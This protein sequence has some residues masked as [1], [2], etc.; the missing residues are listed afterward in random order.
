MSW[1]SRTREPTDVE[2][3]SPLRHRSLA[4][5]PLLAGLDPETRHSALDLGA[6]VGHNL[7]LLSARGCRIRITDL[8][9]SLSVETLE[10]REPEA[11]GPLFARLLPF[12]PSERFDVVFLWDLL[13]YLRPHEIAALMARVTSACAPRAVAL[14]LVSTLRQ[15]PG[16]PRR[17]RIEDEGTL[18]WNAPVGSPRPCPR[19][20]QPELIRLMPGFAVKNSYILRNGVQE[21]LFERVRN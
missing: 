17:Y 5:Q 19:H 21:Y 20:T 10:S 3:G 14:A 4:L 15:I 13:D 11:C 2:G 18:S 6:P 9:R 8:Y 1:F 12:D 7:E 16:T